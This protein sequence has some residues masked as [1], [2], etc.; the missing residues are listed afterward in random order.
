[1]IQVSMIFILFFINSIIS[2]L[3]N[4]HLKN[5]FFPDQDEKLL[6]SRITN[7]LPNVSGIYCDV[8]QNDVKYRN[9]SHLKCI[10][11]LSNLDTS[12]S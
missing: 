9:H 11:Y 10:Y 8:K 7:E 12:N 6:K 1:M 2:S 3:L 5:Q 4:D